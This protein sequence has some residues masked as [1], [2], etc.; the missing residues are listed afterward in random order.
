MRLNKKVVSGDINILK[1]MFPNYNIRYRVNDINSNTIFCGRYDEID[2]VKEKCD[3]FNYD[4]I[5]HSNTKSEID[6]DNRLILAS[7]VFSKYNRLVP[8]YIQ[9]N[10][11]EYDDKTFIQ[12]IKIYWLIGK[13]HIRQEQNI[14]FIELINSLSLSMTK[15]YSSYF[16]AIRVQGFHRLNASFS[17]F[18]N[19]AKTQNFN[20]SSYKYREKL[21]VYALKYINIIR[22]IRVSL[23]TNISNKELI[24]LNQIMLIVKYL[25]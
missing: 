21:K 6:L 15:M 4:Y 3:R 14:T 8:K 5:I 23:D 25:H 16:N 13:W 11:R 1:F 7:V 10:I 2:K 24:L 19:R 12:N 17:S 9:D 22:A 18:L 20:V